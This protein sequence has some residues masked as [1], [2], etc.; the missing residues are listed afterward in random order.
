VIVQE[1]TRI[2]GQLETTATTTLAI[3]GG[4]VG[5]GTTTPAYKLE[6]IGTGRFSSDLTVSGNLTVSGSGPHSFAGT[7]SPT[8]VSAF[9]LTGNITGSGSPNITGIGQFSG[10]TGVFS[11]SVT[12]PLVTSTAALTLSS[13]GTSALTLDSASGLIV[14]N[15]NL[16]FEKGTYDLTLAVTAPTANVTL[17]IPAL[18]TNG[19]LVVDNLSQTL[20]N[21]TLSTGSTWQGNVISVTY[22]GTGLSSVYL[23]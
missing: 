4:N 3:L 8:N 6:V 5:I 18:S 21:K 9:T 15:D 22:G 16:F 14:L 17:T 7:L 20:T 10:S 2:V 1:I 13:G 23:R 11:S 19:N 12:T